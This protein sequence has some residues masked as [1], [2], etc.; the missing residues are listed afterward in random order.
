MLFPSPFAF[1]KDDRFKGVIDI[2]FAK[3]EDENA[4]LLRELGYK[5]I[6]VDD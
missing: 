3:P 2:K 1:D 5:Y 6:Y 4:C